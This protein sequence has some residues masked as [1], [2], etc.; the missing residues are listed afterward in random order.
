MFTGTESADS[1]TGDVDELPVPQQI[2]ISNITCDS[3][4]ISWDMDSGGRERITHYFIDLNKKE[5]KKENK[6]KHKV[7]ATKSVQL[8]EH[9]IQ[10]SGFCPA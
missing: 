7:G 1:S 2:Q 5:S 6:F 4:K 9:F 10:I 3:F 8:L